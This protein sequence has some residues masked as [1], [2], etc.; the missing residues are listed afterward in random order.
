MGLQQDCQDYAIPTEQ[1]E[2][3]LIS[4]NCGEISSGFQKQPI[5]A[6]GGTSVARLPFSDITNTQEQD[7]FKYS[8]FG[9][10]ASIKLG[11]TVSEDP[12]SPLGTC[13]TE[14]QKNQQKTL[15][16][17]LLMNS[18]SL[19]TQ[20]TDQSS[21]SQENTRPKNFSVENLLA[22]ENLFRSQ[23]Q[24]SLKSRSPGFERMSKFE[25]GDHNLNGFKEQRIEG[26][27]FMNAIFLEEALKTP[28]KEQ[29]DLNG[30]CDSPNHFKTVEMLLDSEEKRLDK[31]SNVVISEFT[32]PQDLKQKTRLRLKSKEFQGPFIN[33]QISNNLLPAFQKIDL[34][35]AEF[36]GLPSQAPKVLS[37]NPNL[38]IQGQ[39]SFS[40]NQNL[41]QS[42][43]PQAKDEVRTRNYNP[44]I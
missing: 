39:N 15:Q 14:V 38:N 29:D 10:F 4:N 41:L 32:L 18:L 27:G 30:D 23:S 11:K 42:I 31:F 17:G 7:S 43:S 16:N 35:R 26:E 22:Q 9:K 44:Q 19:G 40:A 37:Q 6:V 20:E 34:E 33:D 1:A 8:H 2:E 13:K 21:I 28:Q 25:P 36:Q 12:E 5:L 24:T 3:L